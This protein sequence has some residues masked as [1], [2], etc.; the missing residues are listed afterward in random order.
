MPLPVLCRLV[1][2]RINRWRRTLTPEAAEQFG[3]RFPEGC[4]LFEVAFPLRDGSGRDIPVSRIA[5]AIAGLVI[6]GATPY[7]GVFA[8]ERR[9]GSGA[10]EQWFVV[11]PCQH[12]NEAHLRV[13]LL[14]GTTRVGQSV[15]A[16]ECW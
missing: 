1:D 15:T 16:R 14:E 3:S 13:A 9:I 5:D 10:G 7:V 4:Q 8:C 12:V 6:S 11:V 2:R